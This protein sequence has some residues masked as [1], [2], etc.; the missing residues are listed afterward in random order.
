MA[1]KT[2]RINAE[3]FIGETCDLPA[4]RMHVSRKRGPP[5]AHA[6]TQRGGGP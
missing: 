4:P 5:K 1:K 6:M 2:G 3:S